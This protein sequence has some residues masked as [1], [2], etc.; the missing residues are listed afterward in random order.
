MAKILLAEVEIPRER[1]ELR[2]SERVQ[3]E[4][5]FSWIVT[6]DCGAL[7]EQPPL[8]VLPLRH[9]LVALNH[10]EQQLREHFGQGSVH[11]LL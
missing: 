2:E 10:G 6:H 7:N 4:A 9:Q 1:A 5:H 3:A 11:F 8:P